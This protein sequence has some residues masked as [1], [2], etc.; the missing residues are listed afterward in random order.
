MTLQ[1]YYKYTADI[2][3]QGLFHCYDMIPFMFN[4]L[5]CGRGRRYLGH[6]EISRL[7]FGYILNLFLYY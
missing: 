2:F 3:R 5:Y 1:L 7:Y 6:K 4:S